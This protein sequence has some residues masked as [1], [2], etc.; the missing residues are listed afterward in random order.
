MNAMRIHAVWSLGCLLYTLLVGVPP[1][2]ST[3]LQ[4]TLERIKRLDYTIPERVHPAA[5]DLVSKLL[6]QDPARRPSLDEVAA[7]AFLAAGQRDGD[8]DGKAADAMHLGGSCSFSHDQSRDGSHASVDKLEA[9]AHRHACITSRDE[10]ATRMPS[11]SPLLAACRGGPSCCAVH[12][13]SLPSPFHGAGAALRGR[14]SKASSTSCNNSDMS[15]PSASDTMSPCQAHSHNHDNNVRARQKHE[16]SPQQQLEAAA[17][18]SSQGHVHPH[19]SDTFEQSATTKQHKAEDHHARRDVEQHT[20]HVAS[21]EHAHDRDGISAHAGVPKDASQSRPHEKHA[22]ATVPPLRVPPPRS[23]PRNDNAGGSEACFAHTLLSARSHTISTPV[24]SAHRPPRNHASSSPLPAAS[25]PCAQRHLWSWS[26]RSSRE[27][28]ARGLKPH[29]YQT[30]YAHVV[31]T[32]KGCIE[33][34][35]SGEQATL[36]VAPCGRHVQ[37]RHADNAGTWGT[38]D[39]FPHKWRQLYAVSFCSSLQFFVCRLPCRDSWLHYA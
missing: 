37:L 11:P 25:C 24:Q 31:I 20:H 1:F 36:V 23:T 39:E 17:H 38:L 16:S 12:T 4:A 21:N 28:D 26:K 30:R 35:P 5:A 22:H 19:R 13:C 29:T 9:Q 7:H 15:V 6:Q 18:K 33:A 34:C 10:P 3:S 8:G 32:N 14:M 2:E 27:L